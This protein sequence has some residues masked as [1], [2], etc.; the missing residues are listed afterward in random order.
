MR[1]RPLG[2]D[3]GKIRAALS[4]SWQHEPGALS[5]SRVGGGS[6]HWIATEPDGTRR[7]VTVDDLDRKP[8]LG[9]D[10]EAVFDGLR[11]SYET[12]LAL[13]TEAKLDFVLAP[14]PDSS[15][16]VMARL[17]SQF[18]IA[19]FPFVEG[20]NLGHFDIPLDDR[21][22]LVHL[23]AE[24]HEA[25]PHVQQIALS[26]RFE[27]PGQAALDDALNQI[28][29]PWTSGPL[30]ESARHWLAA[31]ADRARRGLATYAELA[32]QVRTSSTSVI[33]HGEPHGGNVM[34]AENRLL[35]VDWDTVAFAPAERD[36]WFV[37]DQA[38]RVTY[39]RA[40]GREIDPLAVRLYALGW[41]LS[42]LA[43]FVSVL[44][45]PHRRSNDTEHAWS[46]LS[47]MDLE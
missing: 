29:E 34:R 31:N 6:Y 24:L 3:E 41:M 20:Q 2:I 16:S 40:T 5:Y 26:R 19:V 15:G 47:H 36:L 43:A 39:E 14:I 23:L 1:S 4:K 11:R 8:W 7:F 21:Q 32:R 38:S 37:N 35:L 10:R 27:V 33:T 17:D 42:D 46:V 30:G 45:S 44:R 13:Q 18:T 9:S 28:E 22:S 12:A 25:S